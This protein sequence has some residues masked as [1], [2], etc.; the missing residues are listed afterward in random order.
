MATL[1]KEGNPQER[2]T[3]KPKPKPHGELETSN[4]LAPQTTDHLV[5]RT[6]NRE[7]IAIPRMGYGHCRLGT[8][9]QCLMYYGVYFIPCRQFV[10]SMAVHSWIHGGSC[11]VLFVY[12]VALP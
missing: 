1:R 11:T 7:N 6:D 4:T 12:S 2:D 3:D 8:L 9:A 5:P 10:R